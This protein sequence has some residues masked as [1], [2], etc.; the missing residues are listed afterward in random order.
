MTITTRYASTSSW[1]AE[2]PRD[3]WHLGNTTVRTPYR[4]RDGLLVLANSPLAGNLSGRSQESEFA[5]LL[6][7]AEVV[8]VDRIA[9]GEDADYS[10][11]GR[12]W[13]AALMQ[14]GFI[15]PKLSRTIEATGLDPE[16][17]PIVASFPDLSGRP[18]EITPNGRRLMA[19]ETMPQQQECFLRSLLAYQ[20]PSPLERGFECP[21]FSPLRN[22]LLLLR[23]LED[24]GLE[25]IITTE[26]MASVVQFLETDQDIRDATSVLAQYRAGRAASD[27]KRAFDRAFRLA[28]TGRE[29]APSQT[30][31]DYQDVNFRYLKATGLFTSR[32][33]SILVAPDKQRLVGQILASPFSPREGAE[34]LA[35][36]WS[37]A[38]LPTDRPQ[39]AIEVIDSLSR[40]LDAAGREVAIPPL[41][42]RSAADLGQI[43]LGLEDEWLRVQEESYASRQRNEWQEILGYMRSLAGLPGGP[44]VPRSEAPAYFEWAIWRAFLA[45]DSLRLPPWDCRRFRVDQDF[46]PVG[47]APGNG[48]DMI[49]EFDDYVLVVEV[50]LTTSSRQEA[51]EGEPVRRHVARVVEEYEACRKPVYGL[52]IANT[53]DSNTAETFRIGVWYRP[54]DEQVALTIVPLTLTEFLSLF[55]AGFTADSLAPETVERLIRDCRVASNEVAPRWKQKITEEV[56]RYVTRIGRPQR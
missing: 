21:F 34:Y 36:L 9:A 1:G 56:D 15:S 17:V 41:E 23:R 4:L 46:L 19:A 20:L 6:H 40:L 22:V 45:I 51:A 35:R 16:L 7:E 43:R 18:Y 26:E 39:E 32:G 8:F 5:R 25:P 11:L 42:G 28:Q 37:G 47:T 30:L 31:N 12:K 52:F 14:L 44:Q 50:T 24:D 10:D 49:F 29:G 48:P 33:R 53:V 13:R 54:N 27:D 55:E 2:M 3:V 38:E